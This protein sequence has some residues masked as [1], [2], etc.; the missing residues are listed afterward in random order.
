MGQKQCEKCG[1]IVDEAKAFCPECGHAFV[2]EKKRESVSEFDR[3]NP[4][5]QLGATMFNQMLSDMGLNISKEPN[6]PDKG[7][8]EVIAPVAIP[9]VIEPKTT[10]AT[11]K[12]TARRNWII[13]GVVVGLFL[14]LL[15]A[16]I[17]VA[18]FILYFRGIASL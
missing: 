7:R 11:P 16:L 3:S 4:T 5:V 12:N 14:F 17:I 18:A 2:E 10:P 8:V 13:A 1:E 9:A 15:A 6:A